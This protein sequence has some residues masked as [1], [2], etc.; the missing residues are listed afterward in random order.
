MEDLI[1][2]LPNE[3]L[4][5]ILLNLPTSESVRTSVLPTRWRNLWQSVPGLYLISRQILKFVNLRTPSDVVLEMLISCSP[6]LQVLSICDVGVDFLKVRSQTL[7]S[8]SLWTF[9]FKGENDDVSLGDDGESGL[10]IDT[11]SLEFLRIRDFPLEDFRVESVI[12]SIKMCI[13]GTYAY[14]KLQQLPEF[15]NLTRLYAFLH[16]DYS[17]M[18]PIYLSSSPNLKSIDLE[19]H[20]YPKMEEIASSPVPKCLQTSIENVKIK[21]TPKADQEKSR[22]AETEVANYILENATLL[23][24]TLWLD[25]EEEDESSS[26]LEKILTFQNYSFVEVKIG[27]EASKFRLGYTFDEAKHFSRRFL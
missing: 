27:R 17:E 24:L 19:L 5:E 23:K 10:V 20:G 8:L 7:R 15:K 9:I 25:D 11:P 16:T 13:D 14:T 22:K 18:L 3:L 2:Q 12:S 1:S 21:M 4:Q 26:V 6:V